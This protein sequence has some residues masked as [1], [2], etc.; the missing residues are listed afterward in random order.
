MILFR[1]YKLNLNDRL[2]MFFVFTNKFPHFF[3]YSITEMLKSRKAS[4][5][6]VPRPQKAKLQFDETHQQQISDA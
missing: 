6:D 3:F 4:P 5:V 1:E 2:K